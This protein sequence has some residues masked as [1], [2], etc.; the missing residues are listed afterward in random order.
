MDGFKKRLSESVQ[1]KLSLAL[2]LAILVVGLVAGTFSFMTAFD[3]AN[4][5]QDDVLKQVAQ[6]MDRQ[7]L[8]STPPAIAEPVKPGDE[9]VRVIVQ[10][11]GVAP[12]AAPSAG[13]GVPVGEQ[14]P[15]PAQL[16][17]G[18]H[19]LDVAGERFR[20]LVKTTA[21]GERFAVAQELSFRNAIAREGALRTVMPFLI[22]VPVL[23]LIVADLV[24]KMF[25]PIAVLSQEID[26]RA[27][28]ALHP[29]EDRQLPIEV[30]PFVRAINQ[31]LARVGQSMASQRRFVAD[32]AHELRSPLTAL[33][34]QAERL[35]DADMSAQARERLT[36][37]RQG[38]ERGRNLM[39]QLLSLSRAQSAVDTPRSR[40]SLQDL[41]R[42]VLEDLMPLAEARQIDIGVESADDAWVWSN[43][44]D[45]MAVLRNLVDNAIRYTPP[46]GRVDL[47]LDHSGGRTVLRVQDTG[48][49][50]SQ[51]EQS[52]VFDPFYRVVG[53]EQL[54]SGLGLSI[55]K[56]VCDR[57]GVVILLGVGHPET[58]TGLSVTL[59]FPAA[60]EV[61]V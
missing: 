21:A 61:Q 17:E 54:G 6:L 53:N 59:V 19:T 4:E 31:L 34:L 43:E 24:P 20:V 14:L 42:R 30:R 15:L 16:S 37:L 25:R 46:G 49:G 56:A 5:L 11:L 52:R 13:L 51:E 48:P 36:T 38:I 33:S 40:I 12:S 44:L 32:A 29:I 55:V 57:I 47:R 35:A 60:V 50:I 45:M 3:E 41:F 26:Q 27:E 9:E 39:D 10:P 1:L 2:S 28:Q 18:M 58:Q 7:R 22:L 23:L 8:S